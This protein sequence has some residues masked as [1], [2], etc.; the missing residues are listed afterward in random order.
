MNRPSPEELY[1]Q[2]R[3]IEMEGERAAFLRGACVGDDGLL[4]KVEALLAQDV[5]ASSV[6][7]S[8]SEDGEGPLREEIGSRVDAYKLLQELGEGG[9]GVVY[10]AEQREPVKR[11]VALKVIKLGMDTRQVIARFE[12]ERQALAMM[13]HVGIAK[14]FDAG[15]TAQ[16]RPYFVMELV[17]GLPI[18][19]YCD[20]NQ[21]SIETR[22]DLF[23]QVCAAVQH[24]HQKGIIHRDLKPSNVLV[25]LHDGRPVPKVIDFGI[26]KSTSAELTQKTIFTEL[27]QLIGTPAYMSPEQAELSGLDVDTRADIYSLGVLLYELLTGT[28]PFTEDELRAAGFAGLRR[29]IREQEP[30]KPSTRVSSLESLPAVAAQRGTEP[31]RLSLLIRGD[32]DWIIMRALEKDRTRR[33]DSANEMAADV[34]RFLGREPVLASPPSNAYRLRKFVQRN[35]GPVTAASLILTVGLLGLAGTSLGFFR[36]REAKEAEKH[37]R[38]LAEEAELAERQARKDAE[39]SAETADERSYMASIFAAAAAVRDR[40]VANAKRWLEQAPEDLRDWEWRHLGHQVDRSLWTWRAADTGDYLIEVSP[41]GELLAAVSTD[42]VVRVLDAGSRNV[43]S[44]FRGYDERVDR[45]VFSP[46]CSLAAT[47]IA[48]QEARI[49]DVESGLQIAETSPM[50]GYPYMRFTSDGSG[51]FRSSYVQGFRLFDAS[52]GAEL[53]LPKQDERARVAAL[54][55]DACRLAYGNLSGDLYLYDLSDPTADAEVDRAHGTNPF[56]LLAWSPDGSSIASASSL[57]TLSTRDA[58]ERQDRCILIRDAETADEILVLEG[59]EEGL[60]HSLAFT[61]DGSRLVSGSSGSLKVWDV[62]SGELLA[63]MLGHE[64]RVT[65]LTATND[66]LWSWSFDEVLKAWDLPD[67]EK[68]PAWF[69]HRYPVYCVGASPDGTRVATGSMDRRLIIWSAITGEVLCSLEDPAHR[70][71]DLAWSP[72]GSRIATASTDGEIRIWD[73]LLGEL[74]QALRGHGDDVLA[75]SWSPDGRTLFSGSKDGRV[76]AWAAQRDWSMTTVASYDGWVDCLA[77]S[78]DGGLFAS[79]TKDG[80]VRVLPLGSESNPTVLSGHEGQVKQLAFSPDGSRLATASTDGTLRL[81]QL[82]SGVQLA[83]RQD[84]GDNVNAVSFTPDGARLATASSDQTLRIWDAETCEPLAVLEGHEWWVWDLDF[85]PDG[86]RLYSVS[87]DVSLRVWES[88]PAATRVDR[89]EA[90][91]GARA[92]VGPMVARLL[93]EGDAR[94]AVRALLDDGALTSMQRSA[95]LDLVTTSVDA[96]LARESEQRDFESLDAEQLTEFAKELLEILPRQLRDPER[97]KRYANRACELS[98]WTA[99]SPISTLARAHADLGD[100]AKAVE[101]QSRA[102]E[103]CP[104]NHRLHMTYVAKL[105]VYKRLLAEG[106]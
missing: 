28:T 29:M 69:G 6:I 17:R 44:E 83:M 43:V 93:E 52:S 104:S 27:G 54:S 98:E 41:D 9:F 95:A 75:V 51:L 61:P 30:P 73:H 40:Q 7:R 94:T 81:W 55:P 13:D 3:Q 59:H 62:E 70:L 37:Q 58:D 79:G 103:A 84:H 38:R 2:A 82:P 92:L 89:R 8:L 91:R 68:H 85:A 57:S 21:L 14:V 11:K 1:H 105:S 22:L 63:T 64:H 53:E 10:L 18:T 97:A 96:R 90:Y 24:A 26:A 42:H 25:T 106:R 34:G 100:L 49:W 56:T 102:V 16:G 78:P 12:A 35:R 20:E 77:V 36:E 88:E 48:G 19:R 76:L 60:V 5:Q 80:L 67:A 71:T 66:R 46:D 15:T 72:D 86:L 39:R 101:V 4:S 45:V 31:A 74:D 87:S 47:A 32:L 99:P 50:P 23:R 65:R 33:Y